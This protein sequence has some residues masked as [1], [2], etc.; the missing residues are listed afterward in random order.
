MLDGVGARGLLTKAVC[1]ALLDR[2]ATGTRASPEIKRGVPDSV[3]DS[4]V[5]PSS[6][7]LPVRNVPGWRA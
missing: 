3:V 2:L 4:V 7:R 6:C 1:V 5:P